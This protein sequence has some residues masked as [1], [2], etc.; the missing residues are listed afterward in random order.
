MALCM[1]AGSLLSLAFRRVCVPSTAL[2]FRWLVC[3]LKEFLCFAWAHLS[4]IFLFFWRSPLNSP[5]VRVPAVLKRLVA[6][7]CCSLVH[8]GMA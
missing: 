1:L 2:F 8:L 7:S 5:M 3:R 6:S 4:A